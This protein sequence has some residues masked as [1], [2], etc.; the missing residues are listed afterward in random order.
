MTLHLTG[1]TTRALNVSSY[2]Y[3][4]FAQTQGPYADAVEVGLRKYGVSTCGP[5]LES[6]T[7]DLHVQAEWLVAKFLGTEDAILVSMGFAANS[8]NL[9][10]LVDRGCLAISYEYNHQSV[11][12]G[13]RISGA[14]VRT[15]KHNDM[16]SLEALLR[17]VI[18]QGQPRTHRPWK[19]I[20]VVVEG[21]HS[22]EATID[23]P[24]LS[25]LKGRYKVCVFFRYVWHI[26]WNIPVL[27]VY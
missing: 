20:L 8:T 6:G 9:P 26:V 21:L 15:F 5:R 11:H 13:A 23:L 4:G 17:E 25:Q 10:G 27:S 22:M 2:D 1:T 12:Y 7:T 3:L 19:K 24:S 16:N 14:H 18:S